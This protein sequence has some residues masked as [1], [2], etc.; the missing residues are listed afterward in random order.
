MY[1]KYGK[2]EVSS[3][4][5]GD[6]CEKVNVGFASLIKQFTYRKDGVNVM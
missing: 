4:N 1:N 6:K 3:E 2:R 5:K